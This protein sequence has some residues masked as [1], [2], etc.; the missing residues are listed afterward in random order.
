M[1]TKIIVGQYDGYFEGN[2]QHNLTLS[3]TNGALKSAFP[4]FHGNRWQMLNLGSTTILYDPKRL[5]LPNFVEIGWETAEEIAAEP[6]S[7]LFLVKSGSKS[8][9]S[10][11]HDNPLC[12]FQREYFSCPLRP[13]TYPLAKTP[14]K[15]DQKWRKNKVTGQPKNMYMMISRV[16]GMVQHV[17]E[18]HAAL[19]EMENHESTGDLPA[20]GRTIRTTLDITNHTIP[21]NYMKCLQP[22][23]DAP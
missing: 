16:V 15:S 1:V 19:E 6:G 12:I 4:I 2:L 18:S 8:R 11:F 20:T 22:S 7:V 14:S 9:I 17:M 3:W 23:W 5:T 10:G 21:P 13:K